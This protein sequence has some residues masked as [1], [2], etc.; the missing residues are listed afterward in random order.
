MITFSYCYFFP[1]GILLEKSFDFSEWTPPSR[2]SPKQ[3]GVREE[4]DWLSRNS[5]EL[6]YTVK[7][8]HFKNPSDALLVLRLFRETHFA[9]NI[10]CKERI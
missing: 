4:K 2:S 6:R 9:A 7:K 10:L 3:S 8:A 1:T 5:V